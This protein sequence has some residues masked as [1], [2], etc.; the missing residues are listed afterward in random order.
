MELISKNGCRFKAEIGGDECEGVIY[1]KDTTVY[2]LQNVRDGNAPEPFPSELGFK[3]SWNVRR[4][5]EED[6]D[7][8]SV[9]NF[10]LIESTSTFASLGNK[11]KL[12][13]FL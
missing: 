10:V 4:G 6:L 12:L 5:T 1:V 9:E 8:N 7:R 2:L 13:L 11:K 3:H